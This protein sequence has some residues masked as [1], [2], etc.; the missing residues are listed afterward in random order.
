ME[1]YYIKSIL[2]KN[3]LLM[4]LIREAETKVKEEI[5]NQLQLYSRKFV[6]FFIFLV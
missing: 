4:K 6:C 2:E 3:K 1:K 5:N